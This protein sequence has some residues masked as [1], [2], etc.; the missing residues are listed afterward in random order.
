M[1]G[2][3]I[4][5]GI[6]G[7]GE[8]VNNSYNTGKIYGTGERIGGIIGNMDPGG[9]IENCYNT[10]EI[11]GE[12]LNVGGIAGIIFG[13][14]ENSYNTGRIKGNAEVGGIAGQIGTE[15]EANI[16]NCYNEGEIVANTDI[17]GGIVGWISET[18]TSG[19]IENNYNK[20]IV[21]GG[22]RA[23]GIIG[24]NV[25][26]F[27]VTKCYNKGTVE[28]T[29]NVGSVIGEQTGGNDNLSKLYYLSTLNIGGVNGE[30]IT[31]KVIGVS[32]DINS[33]NDFLTWIESK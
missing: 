12:S 7:L 25:E 8:V 23:G 10:G 1:K 27:V 21:K 15:C 3:E 19:T 33:Y 22:N 11:V 24:R 2:T 28:G 4:I 17:A 30:D 31:D 29:T 5:S 26:A 18:G 13:T 16:R 20:G 9:S 14:I 6:I 32:D